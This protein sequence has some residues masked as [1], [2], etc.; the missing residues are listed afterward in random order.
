MLWPLPVCCTEP[1]VLLVVGTTAGHTTQHTGPSGTSRIP[2]VGHSETH[3]QHQRLDD[4]V[5]WAKFGLKSH[6]LDNL[7][8]ETKNKR[9]TVPIPK[10]REALGLRNRWGRGVYQ[11]FLCPVVHSA[12]C[13]CPHGCICSQRAVVWLEFIIIL[14]HIIFD[15]TMMKIQGAALPC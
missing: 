14:L 4:I 1:C 9:C 2:P 3:R 6:M 10:F 8:L 5:L 7:T 12:H 15:T 11:Q 13:Y